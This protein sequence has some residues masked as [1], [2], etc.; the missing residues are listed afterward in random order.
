MASADSRANA[1]LAAS[2][3]L[4]A[5]AIA[6]AVG[7]LDDGSAKLVWTAGAFALCTAGA[8][9]ASFTALWPTAVAAVGWTAQP[10]V[11]DIKSKKP[12]EKI[13]AEMVAHLHDRVE[14]N[15]ACASRLTA[16]IKI[17]MLMLSM[18]PVVAITVGLYTLGDFPALISAFLAAGAGAFI[19]QRLT[20]L[21]PDLGK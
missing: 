12:M 6:T 17:A 2:V 16:R 11:S 10:F 9:L 3:A 1:I 15:R 18:A 21:Y 5:A 14:T 13:K 19:S 8:A 20:S 7:Q 4:S